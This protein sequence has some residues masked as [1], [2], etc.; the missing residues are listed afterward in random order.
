MVGKFIPGSQ[1]QRILMQADRP[2][3]T[4][5]AG[6]ARFQGAHPAPARS[7]D[8]SGAAARLLPQRS[9]PGNQRL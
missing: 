3:L 1:A 6:G 2:V 8:G 9:Q 4:M 7:A 5:K